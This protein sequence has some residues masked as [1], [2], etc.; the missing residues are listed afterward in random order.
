MAKQSSTRP[1]P[2]LAPLAAHAAVYAEITAQDGIEVAY[3]TPDGGNQIEIIVDANF[4][5]REAA[6]Q[7]RVRKAPCTRIAQSMISPSRK[8]PIV[9]R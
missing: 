3:T 4:A 2:V 6:L 9:C 5:Q 8:W 7:A 1:D